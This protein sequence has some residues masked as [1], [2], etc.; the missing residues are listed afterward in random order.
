MGALCPIGV[1][2][3][4]VTR[5]ACSCRRARSCER[6]AAHL[7]SLAK[8]RRGKAMRALRLDGGGL[9]LSDVSRPQPPAGEALIRV[10]LAG[11]CHTDQEL[12]RGYMS[13]A[14]TPGHEFVGEIVALGE[15]AAE[16][17]LPIG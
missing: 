14:G 1:G 7:H 3:R 10:R 15:G 12:A 2:Q 11:I 4:S 9:R 8:P 16:A 17:G 13:F 6:R 5:A